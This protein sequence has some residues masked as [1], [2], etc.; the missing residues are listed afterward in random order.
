MSATNRAAVDE[1][2]QDGAVA[3]IAGMDV[4]SL[5]RAEC[6]AL[7][8]QT[9]SLEGRLFARL[10]MPHESTPREANR[11]A[12]DKLLSAAETAEMLG[13]E[14]QWVYRHGQA[15]GPV[16]LV[17]DRRT[18]RYSLNAIREYIAKSA[19]KPHAR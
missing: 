9:K 3:Q 12:A 4:S 1:G 15:L 18:L 13:V 10:L 17:E 2:Y 7:L 16:K 14:R 8:A 6:A 19:A 5:T 11:D